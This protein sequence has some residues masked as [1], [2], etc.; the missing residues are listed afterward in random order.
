MT[1]AFSSFASNKIEEK[2]EKSDSVTMCMMFFSVKQSWYGKKHVS[3]IKDKQYEKRVDNVLIELV[4]T[5]IQN[6][7]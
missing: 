5:H 3:H 1:P 7:K 6:M 2:K 4:G